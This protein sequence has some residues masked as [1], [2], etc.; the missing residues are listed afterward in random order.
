MGSFNR[1]RVEH[2]LNELLVRIVP[3]DPDQ[4]EEAANQRFDAAFEF[5]V[6]E[7]SA[8][9]DG[10]AAVVPDVEHIA[11]LMDATSM[12]VLFFSCVGEWLDE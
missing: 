6:G 9:G 7:L 10:A 3:D 1:E 8:A 5:A 2:A 12:W 11:S 4:D